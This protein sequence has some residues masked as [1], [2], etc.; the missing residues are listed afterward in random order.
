MML[1]RANAPRRKPPC[2]MPP[3]CP[4]CGRRL[5][6]M[7]LGVLTDTEYHDVKTWG[8]PACDWAERRK[9]K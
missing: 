8:C 4:L 5:T 9:E 3:L 7:R 6:A 1:N 2:P